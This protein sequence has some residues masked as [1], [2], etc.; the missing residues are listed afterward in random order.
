MAMRSLVKLQKKE[1]VPSWDVEGFYTKQGVV[2]DRLLPKRKDGEKPQIFSVDTAPE[3]LEDVVKQIKILK[4]NFSQA[5]EKIKSHPEAA[6]ILA[7]KVL[8]YNRQNPSVNV[9]SESVAQKSPLELSIKI[10]DLVDHNTTEIPDFS[11]FTRN[12]EE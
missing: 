5:W 11:E 7:E 1:Y 12:P 9:I 2:Q 3:A 6:K 10:E 8:H 4:E